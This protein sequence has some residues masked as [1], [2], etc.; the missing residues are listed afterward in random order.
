LVEQKKGTLVEEEEPK[1][2]SQSTSEERKTQ[3]ARM[4][5]LV[6]HAASSQSNRGM[7]RKGVHHHMFV[8]TCTNTNET[9]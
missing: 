4:M 3:K 5:K 6:R 2:P 7:G 9:H 8:T 1:T